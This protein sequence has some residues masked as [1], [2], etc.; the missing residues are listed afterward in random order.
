MITASSREPTRRS[1]HLATAALTTAS[2]PCAPRRGQSAELAYLNLPRWRADAEQGRAIASSILSAQLPARRDRQLSHVLVFRSVAAQLL[3][4]SAEHATEQQHL[5]FF[6]GLLS[7]AAEGW[8]AGSLRVE[9]GVKL[10][11]DNLAAVNASLAAVSAACGA[12]GAPRL[13]A[14]KPALETS[15]PACSSATTPSATSS[16]AW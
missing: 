2:L 4:G 8:A 14:M 10:S 16:S 7:K 1:T 13:E 6:S 9:P 15:S 5:R 3:A 12:L 11:S